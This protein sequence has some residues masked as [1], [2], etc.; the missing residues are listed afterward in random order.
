MSTLIEGPPSQ[1]RGKAPTT[2]AGSEALSGSMESINIQVPVGESALTNPILA[3][4]L[5]EAILLPTEKRSRK[6]RTMV[7]MFSS[8]YSSLISVAHD[9]SALERGLRAYTDIHQGWSNKTVVAHDVSAL[10]RGLRAYTDIHQGWSNKTV[11]AIAER[12]AT[13]ECLQAATN[14]EEQAEEIS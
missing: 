14:R 10:E 13:L 2:S 8:F 4:Q 9:V 11:V 6:S 12:D 7:D 3:K 5:V 1:R